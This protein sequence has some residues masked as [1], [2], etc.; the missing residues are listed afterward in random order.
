MRKVLIGARPCHARINS[1]F[2]R[3]PAT[4]VKSDRLVGFDFLEAMNEPDPLFDA[5]TRAAIER[6]DIH[7]ARIQWAATKPVAK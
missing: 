7:L 4:A 3:A 1:G 5:E 2:Y 6:G